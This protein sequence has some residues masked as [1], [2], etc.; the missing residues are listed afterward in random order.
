MDGDSD[1]Y[2]LILT[3]IL[4]VVLIAINAFFASAEMAVVSVNQNRLKRVLDSGDKRAEILKK[5]TSEPTRFLSTIQVAI[6]LA[7]F[8]SSATA[9]SKISIYV[10]RL[11]ALIGVKMSETVAMVLVTLILSYLNL[12]FG[13]LYPKKLA[14]KNPEKV[15]LRSARAIRFVMVLFYPFVRLL[16]RSTDLL[17][18]LAGQDRQTEE[19]KVTEDEIRSLIVT[20]HVEGLIKEE[21][22]EMLESIFK[23]DDLSADEIMTPRTDVFAVNI[24]KP[25][26]EQM[27]TIISEGFSRL[28]V[29]KNDI[30]NIVGVLH[31]KD[32]LKYANKYGFENIP[33]EKLIRKPYFV[34]KHIKIDVLFKKMQATNNQMAILIDEYGGF[35][36]IVTIE[37]L[38]EEI[39]GNI[40]DEY[41]EEDK[42]I[43]K[44]DDRTYLVDG[45]IQIQELNKRLKIN[46]DETDEN[47]DTL[48]GLITYILG[49]IPDKDFKEEIKYDNLILKVNKVCSNKIEEVLL[50]IKDEPEKP[51]EE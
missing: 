1:P 11:F 43:Q 12:I 41:D 17:F 38:V 15:A 18:K 32:I 39:V 19:E 4:I 42:S 31:V 3:L 27:D 46:I 24:D 40:Y 8:L 7:G 44:L 16:T 35:V 9:G 20:G 5:L 48:G 36:G 25:L 6:T 23:F 14:L 37:D 28:P 29:F 10:V 49:Y 26:T 45:G 30:D 22:K 51:E 33:V 13:E 2:G 21:E 47:F 34:P 50:T